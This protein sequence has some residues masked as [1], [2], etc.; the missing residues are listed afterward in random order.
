MDAAQARTK[1]R[2]VVTV[3][4]QRLAAG[5]AA[6]ACRLISPEGVEAITKSLADAPGACQRTLALILGDSR[7]RTDAG[8]STFERTTI[9]GT[10][11]VATITAPAGRL[12]VPVRQAGQDWLID[13]P[14]RN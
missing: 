7:V 6:G 12:I 10:R 2:S 9:T 4:L 14:T 3:Y 13:G 5:D 11:A 8:H 1:I